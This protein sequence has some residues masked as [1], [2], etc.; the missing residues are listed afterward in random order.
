MGVPEMGWKVIVMAG[1]G[2]A[3]KAPSKRART[4]K[5]PI[6]LRVVEVERAVQPVLPEFDVQVSVEGELVS[7]SFEWP[8]ATRD[9]WAMLG[10]HPLAFEFIET[11]W[12]YLMDTA[13]LH[14][15]FWQGDLKHAAELRLRE[16]K[17]G[18]TPEDRAR[19][20]LQF[21]QATGAEEDTKRKVS[22]VSSRD[23]YNAR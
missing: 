2:P 8:Q 20:R 3:P 19:L 23:R 5:D 1:R 4:N 11:D 12:A 18:F 22:G 7:Q 13:R 17:Y 16:A 14:A 9:W 6:P 21:A 15:A 10:E